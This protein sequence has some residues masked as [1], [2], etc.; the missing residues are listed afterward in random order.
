LPGLS[1]GGV[2]F[3]EEWVVG[4]MEALFAPIKIHGVWMKQILKTLLRVGALR[5]GAGPQ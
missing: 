5:E 1:G 4:K 2:R 3:E